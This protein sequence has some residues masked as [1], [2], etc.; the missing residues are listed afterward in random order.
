[1]EQ[2]EAAPSDKCDAMVAKTTAHVQT[3]AGKKKQILAI[4][5]KLDGAFLLLFWHVQKVPRGL[6]RTSMVGSPC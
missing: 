1:V 4:T 3:K 5:D 6:H 2:R